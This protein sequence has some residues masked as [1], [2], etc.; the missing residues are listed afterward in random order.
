MSPPINIT[1]KAYHTSWGLLPWF[2]SKE[3]ACIEGDMCSIPGL[4]R[5]SGDGNHNPLQSSCLG[6]PMDREAWWA[7]VHRVAK[8]QTWLSAHTHTHTHTHH[9]SR[10]PGTVLN[11]LQILANAVLPAAPILE[12]RKQKPTK[13]KPCGWSH[14]PGVFWRSYHTEPSLYLPHFM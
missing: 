13:L 8:S 11:I 7:I 9:T 14:I 3:S 10:V 5:S 4:G 2:S 1:A 6:N 12:M